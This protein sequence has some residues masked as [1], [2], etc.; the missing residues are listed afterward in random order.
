MQSSKDFSNFTRSFSFSTKSSSS[1]LSL[2]PSQPTSIWK[3][4]A[5]LPTGTFG[6][7]GIFFADRLY[8]GGG[9]CRDFQSERIVYEYDI[10][11]TVRKWTPLP[12][13]PVVYFA[14]A[15]V[16][17]TL[18]LVGGMD[19]QKKLA[20]NEIISW[21][22]EL[23]RWVK[24]L[25]PM[26]ISRQDCT[27]VTHQ[28]WLLVAGGVNNKKPLHNVELLKL[29]TN[30]WLMVSPLPKPSVG[31]TSCVVKNTC[32]LLGGVN[33]QEPRKGATGPKEYVFSLV[34]D[35]NIATNQWVRLPDTPLYFCSAVSFGDHVMTVGGTDS[36]ICRTS[37][38]SMF[39]YSPS[40]EKWVYTGKMPTPRSQ[41]TCVVLSQGR[42]AV[43]GGQEKGSKFSRVVEILHC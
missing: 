20:T 35:E 17:N 7:K 29:D 27:A 39:L 36:P 13:A 12:S 18:N 1:S 4:D 40:S 28:K 26:R 16:K 37:S 38:S 34:I 32:Y 11:G 8:L 19:V 25:P 30:E 2:L 22:K 31:M 24:T 14:M 3:K 23:Q 41:V 42:L 15:A 21:D 43:L 9:D 10:N 33:F 5:D 6:S